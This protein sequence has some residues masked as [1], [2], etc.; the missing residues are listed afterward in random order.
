VHQA[1]GL[2]GLTGV[3]NV[4][5]FGV[6]PLVEG[7]VMVTLGSPLRSSGRGV[8]R[9]GH[10]AVGPSGG[11]HHSGHFTVGPSGGILSLRVRF[12]PQS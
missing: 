12:L 2:P 1:K 8:L 5:T 4:G 9:S 3:G 7:V 10:F 11:V 6:D